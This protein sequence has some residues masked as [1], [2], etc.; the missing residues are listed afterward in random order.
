MFF[1]SLNQTGYGI[2]DDIKK[3]LLV[4]DF[5]NDKDSSKEKKSI[6]S[7]LRETIE[8]SNNE[9]LKTIF[10]MYKKEKSELFGI[11]NAPQDVTVFMS[12]SKGYPTLNASK[13]DIRGWL[14]TFFWDKVETFIGLSATIKANK[15]DEQAFN[16]LGVSRGTFQ[17]WLDKIETVEKFVNTYKRFPNEDDKEYL[18]LVEFI[19]VQKWIP[20][21]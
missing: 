7:I 18:K 13:G 8:K 3:G 12:P 2:I 16:R 11:L 19:E 17:G 20:G 1:I 14:L 10:K 21:L 6:D 4:K 9:S 15:E 5:E